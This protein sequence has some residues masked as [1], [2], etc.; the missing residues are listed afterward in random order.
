VEPNPWRGYRR[1]LENLGDA[2]HVVVL[3]DDTL[4]C[5]NFAQ[6][7]EQIVAARPS[8]LTSLFVGGLRNFNTRVFMRAL[9]ARRSWVQLYP[10]QTACVIH[11]CAL[12][13]PAP[14]A[15][16]FL[17]WTTTNAVRLPGHRGVPKSDDAVVSYW[18]KMTRQEVWATV[19][20]LV[21][22]PDDQPV[23]AGHRKRA[24]GADKGRVAVRWIGSDADPLEIDWRTG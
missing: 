10:M 6:A 5:R 8:T 1:C 14:L 24:D 18:A 4:A 23:V 19:P 17:D 3:Q 2:S 15:R 13:W 11:V 21:E 9:T 20:S 7:V 16:E 22:H 12:V